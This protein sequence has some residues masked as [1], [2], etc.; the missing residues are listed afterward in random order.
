MIFIT[1]C[2]WKPPKTSGP[3]GTPLAAPARLP[4]YG[5]FSKSGYSLYIGLAYLGWRPTPWLD[6]SVGRVPQPLYTTPMV[7]DSDYTPE[8][9]VEKFKFTI[10]PVDYFAT[11]GKYV[12]QD[13][14]PTNAYGVIKGG[15]PA[16]IWGTSPTTTPTCWLGNWGRCTTSTPTFPPKLR[17]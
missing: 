5:P 2:G 3:L 9:A 17:L 1:G 11:L 10:G 14:T 4:L 8:G 13:D 6:I 12:Y 7:W 15:P 16:S